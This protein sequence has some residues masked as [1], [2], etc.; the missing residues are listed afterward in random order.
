MRPQAGRNRAGGGAGPHA[1]TTITLGAMYPFVAGG[2]L[3]D[4]GILVG[5]DRL[6]GSGFAW[7]PFLAYRQQR[8][9][10]PGCLVLGSVGTRKS[11]L[12]K[13]HLGRAALFGQRSVVLDPKGE[14]TALADRLGGR[15]F[16]LDPAGAVGFSPFV[17]GDRAAG[18]NLALA[19][20]LVETVLGSGLSQ[21]SHAV[22]AE[23]VREM[24]RD[25]VPTLRALIGCLDG[26][27][28]AMV[29]AAR[30]TSAGWADVARP[31][32]HALDRLTGKHRD[33]AGI[34]DGDRPFQIGDAEFVVVDLSAAWAVREKQPLVLPLLMNVAMAAIG[35]ALA[36]DRRPTYL[37][38][39]EAWA[40][41]SYPAMAR[42]VAGW[43]KLARQYAVST[44]LVMHRLS[45]MLATAD[46]DTAHREVVKGLLSD[47]GTFALF[48]QEPQ[49]R[50]L[51]R[52]LL[53][54][55]AMTVSI[56]TDPLSMMPG[57][58]LWK[59]GT[60]INLVDHMLTVDELAVADTDSAMRGE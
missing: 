16:A 9:Q 59:V 12:V 54:M 49:E 17:T 30:M 40:V 28:E 42:W 34:L 47:V 26:P 46:A 48:R 7:D 25:Q 11:T 35:E 43:V 32:L 44:V 50:P 38:V 4:G 22:L 56:V 60:A 37:V 45:D 23:A 53:G 29:I 58:S 24:S 5:R 6:S 41:L 14:Y 52:G 33:L 13:S 1:A 39:D 3:P 51:L 36:R 19:A 55:N 2:P 20:A 10:S 57:R 18:A 21:D 27:S 8:V 31:V 15:V